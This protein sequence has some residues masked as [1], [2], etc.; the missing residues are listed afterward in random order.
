MVDPSE[1][2]YLN[3]Q[4]NLRKRLFK[5][6]SKK[7]LKQISQKPKQPVSHSLDE[8]KEQQKEIK[9]AY[10]KRKSVSKDFNK[11]EIKEYDFIRKKTN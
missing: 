4:E 5:E 6:N 7:I 11:P 10:F 1:L 3:S 2:E 8:L 9:Q